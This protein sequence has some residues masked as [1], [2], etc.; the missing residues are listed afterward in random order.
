M[1]IEIKTNCGPFVVKK[2]VVV[3]VVNHVNVV[4]NEV[5]NVVEN[6]EKFVQNFQNGLNTNAHNNEKIFEVFSNNVNTSGPFKNASRKE[7]RL[8]AKPWLSRGKFNHTINKLFIKLQKCFYSVAYNH[9]QKYCNPLNRV[10]K[11]QNKITLMKQ[12]RL[13]KIIK[14]SY[15]KSLS[16]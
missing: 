2:V 14:T 5:V 11:L 12:L 13:I 7:K 6:H 16:V 8:L 9:Y 1:R 10:I 4:E 15:G 3:E